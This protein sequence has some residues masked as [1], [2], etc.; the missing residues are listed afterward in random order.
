M[1]KQATGIIVFLTF[2]A[3][4]VLIVTYLLSAIFNWNTHFPSM[5]TILDISGGFIALMWMLVIIKVPWDLYFETKNVLFEMARS[6]EKHISITTERR[7]YV[8]RMRRITGF[9]AVAAHIISSS[10]IAG[11][12]YLAH[13]EIGYYFAFFYLL[14][15]FFRPAVEAYRYLMAKLAEI[16]GEVKVPREDAINLRNELDQAKAQLKLLAEQLDSSNSRITANEEQQRSLQANI[17]NLQFALQRAE[18][19]YES[20]LKQLTTE[21]ERMMTKA[22]DQQDVVNGLRAFARL[23]KEA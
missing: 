22:F 2:T 6:E 18:Q 11:I 13:G 15:T 14:T 4:L 20:R 10:I 23:I 5:K 7:N 12:T 16:R 1:S 8:I 21:I 17:N 9:I 3:A 19:T